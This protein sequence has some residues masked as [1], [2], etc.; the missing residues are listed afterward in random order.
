[1]SLIFDTHAH[2]DDSAFNEDREKVLSTLPEKGVYAVVNA[3]ADVESSK[4]SIEIAE[5]Y[6]YIYAAVGVH[7]ENISNINTE[8]FIDELENLILNNKKVVAV[9]EIGLDYHYNSENK[10][11]QK[12]VFESQ[13]KLALKHNLPILVHDREAHGDMLELL[14]KH[15]PKGI[16]HCFSGSV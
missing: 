7:P 15:S 3:G 1:M 8:S 4:K 14:K 6:S 12:T 10:D 13:I 9:G 16:V 5:R 2:Y 11:I